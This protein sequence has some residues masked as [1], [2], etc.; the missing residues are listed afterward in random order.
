[1]GAR[2]GLI[3]IVDDDEAIRSSLK[4]VLE[5]DGLDVRACAG[6]A[7]FLAHPEFEHCVCAV[8]D[9]SMPHCDGLDLIRR[10]TKLR[11]E[12]P[13]VLITGEITGR[14]ERE[15]RKLGVQSVLEKPMFGN[16]LLDAIRMA[17]AKSQLGPPRQ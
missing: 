6:A 1:M 5:L 11:P 3:F 7:E 13:A 12:I 17:M 14:L 16:I 15:A 9:Y 4:F 10:M 8:I 2:R